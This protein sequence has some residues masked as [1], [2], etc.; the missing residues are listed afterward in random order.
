MKTRTAFIYLAVFLLLAGYFYYF[1]VVRRQAQRDKED[2]D[3]HLFQIQKDQITSLH[4]DKADAKPIALNRNGHWQ[5]TEPIHSRADGFAVE[6]VLSTLQ[7]LRM[8]REVEA[9]AQNLQ[10]YGLHNPK[11]HLSF[12]ANGTPHQ[13]RLGAKAVVGDQYYASGDQKNRVVLINATQ[14]QSLDKGL[15]DLRTKKFFTFTSDQVDRIEII[16]PESR[17]AVARLNKQ[18]WQD[19]AASEIKIKSS[20]VEGLLSR[21]ILLRAER[22]VQDGKDNMARFGLDPARIRISL[23]AEG[24]TETLLLGSSS[25]EQT[26]YAKGENMAGVAMVAEKSL[27]E[28]PV[29]LSDLEDRTLFSFDLDQIKA[30]AIQLP[31]ETARL[32]RQKEKWNWS[33]NDHV[34]EPENWQVNSLLWK[35]QELEY[36][37]GAP[38]NKQPSPENVQL[39]LVLLTVNDKKLS[40]F[41]LPEVPADKSVRGVLWFSKGDETQHPFWLSVESLRD[42]HESAKKLLTPES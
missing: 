10:P 8:E 7:S 4:F 25:E 26:A 16:R 23:A 30:V 29:T 37:P 27:E 2:A 22:F 5:I 9:A 20:R 6:N 18:R 15:F 17:L 1:E 3:L 35:L 12:E 14:Q 11:L 24:K 40:T 28:I 38:P 21:L 13:L 36:L 34:K 41:T 31:G 19:A 33:G 32:E 42:L 39:G